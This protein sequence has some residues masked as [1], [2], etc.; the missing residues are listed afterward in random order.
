MP[1]EVQIENVNVSA[2]R[3]ISYPAAIGGED[4]WIDVTVTVKNTSATSQH[5]IANGRYLRYDPASRTLEVGF[6]EPPASQ[7]SVLHHFSAPPV[8][9]VPPG[10][11]R[12]IT[13]VV[14]V[15]MKQIQFSPE[16]GMQMEPHD[17]GEVRHV[18][19]IVA[20]GPVPPP[21]EPTAPAP[22]AR[23]RVVDWGQRAQA[24]VTR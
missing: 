24:T 20:Y 16:S 10:G 5:V 13:A 14:P 12:D 3:A 9:E 17:L 22:Q 19:A 23:Q 21:Y 8:V 1:D 7:Y 15:N 2:P 4:Q 18:T 11:T 6:F